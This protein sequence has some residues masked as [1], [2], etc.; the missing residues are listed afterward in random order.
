MG[1]DMYL[2]GEKYLRTDYENPANNLTEDGFRLETQLL[3][4]GYWRKHPN[5]H[6]FIVNTFADGEDTCQQIH[7]EADDIERIIDAVTRDALPHTDG[8]FFGRSDGSEKSNDLRILN[9]ALEWLRTPEP[10]IW[11]SFTIRQAGR[12]AAMTSIDCHRSLRKS[13]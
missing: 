9:V 3:R 5:L 7:L 1:L 12:E 8:F 2:T 4:L 6:G 10:N 11:R 13:A